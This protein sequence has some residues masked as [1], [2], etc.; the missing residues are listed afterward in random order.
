MLEFINIAPINNN[1][2]K[3]KNLNFFLI[4]K[5]NINKNIDIKCKAIAV[6][7]AEMIIVKVTNRVKKKRFSKKYFFL[8]KNK[9]NKPTNNGKNLYKTS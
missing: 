1:E 9:T 6:L 5:K 8:W 7:S 4:S 2:I 3:T